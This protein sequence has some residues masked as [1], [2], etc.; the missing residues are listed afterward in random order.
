MSVGKRALGNGPAQPHW[1]D[2]KWP[3]ST[4][5]QLG[6]H[7]HLSK[8]YLTS[9][10]HKITFPKEGGGLFAKNG[11]AL[12][13]HPKCCV[14]HFYGACWS[15]Q[16]ASL[17]VPGTSSTIRFAASRGPRGRAACTEPGLA[18]SLTQSWPL[19]G[20]LH[21]WV[22]GTFTDESCVVLRIQKCL[23]RHCAFSSA[24]GW[25]RCSNLPF[26]LKGLSQRP[27]VQLDT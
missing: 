8:S 26:T 1:H 3:Q 11:L 15:L 22:R 25:V 13:Q 9:D 14:C 7:T 23:L 19:T 18:L 5:F 27:P 20:S 21:K 4:P 10:N 2:T 16:A 12:L 17:S 6:I 24:V